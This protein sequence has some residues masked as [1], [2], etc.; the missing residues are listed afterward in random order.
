INNSTLSGA[1][2]I[3]DNDIWAVGDIAGTS[4]STEATLAEHFDGTAWSVIPTPAVSGSMFSSVAGV[5]G[6][7]VW[8][9]GTQGLGGSG[10][11]LIE[12]WNGTNWSMVASPKLP[13]GSF[14]TGV[15]AILPTDA[16]AVGNESAPASST[17]V[18]SPVIEHWD[19]KIWS[20]VTSP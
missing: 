6:N 12:H 1:A 8:A 11:V 13:K 19:G 15:A 18:F 17:F 2:I 16:W 5:V 10:N 9:V 20:V 3:A 4:A 14:L 7:D